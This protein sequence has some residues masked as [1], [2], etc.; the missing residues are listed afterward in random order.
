MIVLGWLVGLVV[1]ALLGAAALLALS[2][3][4]PPAFGPLAPLVSGLPVL[5]VV[6]LL[7]LAYIAAYILATRSLTPL[8]PTTAF[9]L[10]GA[11]LPPGTTSVLL[12][13][14]PGEL[15]A[16]GILLGLT[17]TL[18]AIILLSIPGV[19][20]LIATWTFVIISLAMVTPVALSPIYHGF[21]GWS[22][23]LFPMSYLATGVGFL[24][25]VV[26]APVAF[27]LGGLG[28]FRLDFTTGVIETAGGVVGLPMFATGWAG[29]SLGNFNFLIA[30]AAQDVF[31]E[32]GLSSHETGHSLNTAALGGVVLWINAIDEN[33]A[34]FARQNLAY[35]ELS[36]ESH[37][38]GLPTIINPPRI[39]FFIRVWG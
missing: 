20:L 39:D 24:L 35:G 4:L 15:F 32:N 34:P 27:A 25:F 6:A 8:L 12:G 38:Q 29:F 22:A 37:A 30:P 26:N 1:G 31:V 14:V 36:A 21:L 19:G 9:P 33:V 10:P 3:P 7:V 5:V 23:W 17:A 16:R 28:A 2:V 13:P 11:V 18:N